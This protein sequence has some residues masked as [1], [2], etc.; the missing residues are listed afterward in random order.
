LSVPSTLALI[1]C[2]VR[3]VPGVNLVVSPFLWGLFMAR[4]D[5][6][7]A[8]ADRLDSVALAP[9]PIGGLR[10]LGII[11]GSILIGWG[12]MIVLFLMIWQFSS[13]AGP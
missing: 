13:P 12:M 6:A 2:L 5:I 7:Q 10:V 1:T 9:R 11:G 4:V 3:L 8:E